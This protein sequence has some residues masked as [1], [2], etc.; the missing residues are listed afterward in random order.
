[1]G[2]MVMLGLFPLGQCT[3]RS[4]SAYPLHVHMQMQAVCL[5][6]KVEIWG[7]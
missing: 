5:W 7:M 1:M 4:G 2:V 6:L 3:P